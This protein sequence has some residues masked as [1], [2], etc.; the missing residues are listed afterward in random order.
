MDES[1]W[2]ILDTLTPEQWGAITRYTVWVMEQQAW[3]RSFP[4]EHP[5]DEAMA[6]ASGNVVYLMHD[7]RDGIYKIG[8]SCNVR[9]RLFAIARQM[10]MEPQ[11]LRYVGSIP[12]PEDAHP[13][14][15]EK[16]THALYKPK[17]IRQSEWFRLTP[18][19]VETFLR[20]RATPS[21]DGALI[22]E[23]ESG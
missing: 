18:E 13:V 1:D 8:W 15:L 9:R 19:D 10:G 22:G 23:V 5:D 16:A 21:A 12:V 6:R 14:T 20:L 17:R 2:L 11:R 3:E 7:I 4:A